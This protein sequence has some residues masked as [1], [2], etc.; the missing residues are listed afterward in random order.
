MP[1]LSGRVQIFA[2]CFK[3]VQIWRKDLGLEDMVSDS[4]EEKYIRS[5]IVLHRIPVRLHFHQS[6][7]QNTRTEW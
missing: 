2:G 6:Q 7:Y 4:G 1:E 5:A 3:F